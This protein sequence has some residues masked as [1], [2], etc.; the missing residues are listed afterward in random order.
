VIV[1]SRSTTDSCLHQKHLRQDRRSA[2][3]A[4][5]SPWKMYLRVVLDQLLRIKGKRKLEEKEQQQQH[6]N[7]ELRKMLRRKLDTEVVSK[8]TRSQLWLEF[9]GHYAQKGRY[10]LMKAMAFDNSFEE[11]IQLV[12]TVLGRISSEPRARQRC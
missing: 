9:T 12:Q 5:T 6:P 4:P 7:N 1:I 10:E 11:I 8:Q 3:S 2:N